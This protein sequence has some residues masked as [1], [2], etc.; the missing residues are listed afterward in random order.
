MAFGSFNSGGQNQGG[1]SEINMVPL[2]DVMLVLVVIFIVTAP[3]MAH[4]IQ[5]DLPRV[6]SQ[7][8]EQKPE[9][10]DLAIRATGELYWNSEPMDLDQITLKFR[11]VGAMEEQP[12]IRIR[13]D[14]EAFYE[15]VAEVMAAAKNNHVRRLGFITSPGSSAEPM[16]S[17]QSS[18]SSAA[19]D[20]ASAPSASAD[21]TTAATS[22]SGASATTASGATATGSVGE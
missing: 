12:S 21:G 15:Q 14:S 5:I 20:G 2:I 16:D 1:M 22:T 9:H 10:I 17:E 4:S 18:E 3:M 6:S 7:P 19:S 11:E 13:A 8:S